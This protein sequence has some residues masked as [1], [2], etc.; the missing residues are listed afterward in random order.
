MSRKTSGAIIA[1]LAIIIVVTVV[2]ISTLAPIQSP[3]SHDPNGQLGSAEQMAIVNVAFPDA[4]TISVMV[5]NTGSTQSSITNAFINGVAVQP[6]A[7]V[8]VEKSSS[9]TITF[10]HSNVWSTDTQFPLREGTSYSIK[11]ITVKG[12]SIVSHE[13]VYCPSPSNP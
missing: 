4:N 9:T 8:P 2:S 6:F 7:T 12:T 1:L 13:A 11:L 5:Q 10:K 3:S